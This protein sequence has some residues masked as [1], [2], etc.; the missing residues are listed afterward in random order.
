MIV[1]GLEGKVKTYYVNLTAHSIDGNEYEI[2]AKS[3]NEAKEKAIELWEEESGDIA[4][5]YE[6][7]VREI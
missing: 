7:E 4:D 5:Y 3:R 1:K 2:K 6:F